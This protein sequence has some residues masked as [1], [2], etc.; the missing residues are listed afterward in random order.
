ML[1]NFIDSNLAKAIFII[2]VSF[3]IIKIIDI[4]YKKA[5]SKRGKSLHGLFLKNVVKAFIIITVII[6]ILSMTKVFQTFYSTIL[7]SSSLLVVVMGFI[8]QEG[9]SN[10][11]HGFMISVFKPFDVGDR[12]E[13]M[14]DGNTI[15]GIV[16]SINLR[17]TVIVTTVDNANVVVPNSKIDNST[18]KNYSNANEV[19]KY[20]LQV[21]ITYKD[22]CDDK[23]RELAKEIIRKTVLENDKTI[24]IRTDK[25]I[26]I[27]VKTEFMESSIRLKTFVITKTY[28]EN[29]E[30]CSEI[31]DK[32]IDEFTKNN[33]DFAYPHIEVSGRII[34]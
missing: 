6:K 25:N 27:F 8:L 30:A 15:C 11:V 2:A 13:I 4:A 20:P 19:N 16:K 1:Q 5:A 26:P 31:T 14:I 10:I 23:K 32:I 29:Y 28:E 21:D 18:L 12:I 9:L 3:I 7:M 17:H 24:D 34:N 33:I 22:G